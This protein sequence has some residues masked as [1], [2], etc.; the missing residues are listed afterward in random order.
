MVISIPHRYD[1]KVVCSSLISGPNSISIPHRYDWKDQPF[2]LSLAYQPLFQFL[3]G[4]IGRIYTYL[5]YLLASEISIPHR[6]DW[7]YLLYARHWLLSR[8]S[9]PHRYDWKPI[10][11]LPKVSGSIISIPHRYDWKCHGIVDDPPVA[12]FQFL[13]GTIGRNVNTWFANW[14]DISIPHRYDWKILIYLKSS[15]ILKY[16]NSS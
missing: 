4:T 14:K 12:A 3:I 11:I 10:N 15:I 7:K 5:E 1:W 13:I 6:Y 9:I 8:I 16:F 2:Y